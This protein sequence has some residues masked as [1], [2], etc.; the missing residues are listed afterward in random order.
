MKIGKVLDYITAT[1]EYDTEKNTD[2]LKISLEDLTILIVTLAL[3]SFLRYLSLHFLQEFISMDMK[4][5]FYKIFM[6]K[7][8][9]FFEQY[10]S[11]ELVSRLS[12]DVNQAKSAVSNNVTYLIRNVVLVLSNIIILYTINWKLAF[13][14]MFII[15]LYAIITR[16]YSKLNKV[17]VK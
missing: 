6:S 3:V 16:Q 1:S 10:K 17:L 2:G 15:P 13:I 11:G 9:Y 14:I 7:D 8:L 12:S 4:N 5:D